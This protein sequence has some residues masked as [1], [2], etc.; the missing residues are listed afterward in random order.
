[1]KFNHISSLGMA[2][3]YAFKIMQNLKQK[4]Q[5]FGPGNP[6]QQKQQ[7]AAPSHKKNNRENMDD[8]RTTSPSRKKPRT[9][10]RQINIVGSGGTSII[11]LGITLLI[12]SQ[13]SRRW[14]N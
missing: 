2:Y 1:M 13:S 4:M 10:E 11:S 6:S 9:L 7:R 3:R 5:Q 12:I 8:I 14:S